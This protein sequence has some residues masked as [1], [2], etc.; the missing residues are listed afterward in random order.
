MTLFPFSKP[1]SAG[2]NQRVTYDAYTKLLKGFTPR[3]MDDRWVL[4]CKELDPTTT[5]GSVHLY[6]SWTGYENLRAEFFL[7][8]NGQTTG[9]SKEPQLMI[10]RIWWET[11]DQRRSG[12]DEVEAKQDFINL[13]NGLVGA[14]LT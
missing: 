9:A 7:L 5:R 11:D 14:K 2:W 6:R 13:V 3:D 1:Q 8:G 12:L 4:E 10:D